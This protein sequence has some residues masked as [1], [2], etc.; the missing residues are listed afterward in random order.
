MNPVQPA[1]VTI[2]YNRPATLRRLLQSIG[3]A[4]YSGK[5]NVTLIIS[6]DRSDNQAEVAAVAQ[7]FE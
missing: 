2:G 7:A 6:L 5:T 1:I 3:R 4:D